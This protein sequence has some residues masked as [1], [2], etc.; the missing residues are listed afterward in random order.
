M[1]KPLGC[2]EDVSCSNQN[3]I[4]W[5]Q[6][7]DK[8]PKAYGV[9]DLYSKL[10]KICLIPSR[11]GNG[12]QSKFPLKKYLQKYIEDGTKNGKHAQT[13]DKWKYT[14][15]ALFRFIPPSTDIRDVTVLDAKN[16]YDS[17]SNP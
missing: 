3:I 16:W 8:D 9:N 10:A 12:I 17:I 5:I 15:K 1:W 7:I 11:I 4:L 2:I 6:K 13:I 14:I